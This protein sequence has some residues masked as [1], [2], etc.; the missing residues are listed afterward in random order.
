MPGLSTFSNLSTRIN[1]S[2]GMSNVFLICHQTNLYD[3]LQIIICAFKRYETT[4][5]M[6]REWI[7]IEINLLA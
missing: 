2:G 6:W 5:T 4:L 1:N 7:E 3:S